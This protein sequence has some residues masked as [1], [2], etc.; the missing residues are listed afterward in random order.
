MKPIRVNPSM[1]D[2]NDL[3]YFL[4]V[5]RHASLSGAGR[6]LGVS[7]STVLRRISA[8][9]QDVGH[10]L[11]DRLPSG[12][13][14]APEGKDMLSLALSVEEQVLALDRVM[15][16]RCEV[17]GGPLRVAT[18]DVLAQTILARH[19]VPFYRSF[20]EIHI[21]LLIGDDYVDLA[22]READVAF[23]VGRPEQESLFGRQ[24]TV[25]GWALY[26]GAEYLSQH[27]LPSGMNDIS[28]HRFVGFAGKMAS[29]AAS[30]WLSEHIPEGCI[31]YRT[32]NLMHLR[33]LLRLG[34]GLGLLPSILGDDDPSLIRVLPPIRSL[35]REGWLVTHEDLKHNTRVQCFLREVGRAI[36]NER[37]RHLG[38]RD[39][40][41]S[42]SLANGED[43][44][45]GTRT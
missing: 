39:E 33:D 22:R 35:D 16:G 9:E 27:S 23:R 37:H 31:T 41:A 24:V 29:L 45:E 28:Q 13:T 44:A 40:R 42:S 3:R 38:A 30:A 11:F 15:A 32:N 18:S 1:F 2:W 6:E 17:V 10:Q 12:Y 36:A 21:E 19:L 43:A 8:L 14:L 25:L 20:P 34:L 5:A 26:G 7:Q 4:A